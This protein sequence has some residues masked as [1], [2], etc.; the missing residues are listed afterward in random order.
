VTVN[1][2]ACGCLAAGW[3]LVEQYVLRGRYE[4]AGWYAAG[5]AVVTLLNQLRAGT[6]LYLQAQRR[7]RSLAAAAAAGAAA[8][9]AILF[10][11]MA[12]G[13]GGALA[14]VAVAAGELVGLLYLI[15]LLGARRAS[16]R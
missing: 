4:Q 9:L 7:F 8:S 14:I 3:P 2:L 1:L 15:V 6:S 16:G 12:W 11:A 13:A 5:W 10:G